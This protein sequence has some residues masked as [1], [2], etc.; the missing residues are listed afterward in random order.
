MSRRDALLLGAALTVAGAGGLPR[1]ARAADPIRIGVLVD[2]SGLYSD[3]SGPTSVTA[4]QMA[5]AEV[6][7]VLGRPVEVIAADHQNQPDLGSSIAREWFD[8]RGVVAIADMTSSAVALAVQKLASDKGKVTLAT[9][10]TTTALINEGCSPT[11][12]LWVQDSYSNTA[13]PSRLLLRQGLSSWFMI[14]ADYAGGHQMQ[15]ALHKAVTDGGGTVVGSTLHPVGT[16]DFSSY[17]LQAQASGAQ[18]VG[19]LNGG[20]DLVNSIKQAA[21]F[22]LTQTQ[23]FFLPG[24]VISDI[25]SLGLEQA[26]GL[27]LMNSFYWDRNDESR[28]WSRAFFARTNRMPGQIQAGTYSAVRHFL[29]SAQLAGSTDGAAV[30]ESMRSTPVDDVFVHDG[31]IRPDGRLVHDFYVVQVK[32]P[33]ESR[34]PWDCYK[35]VGTIAGSE[36]MQPLAQT[37]CPYLVKQE[38]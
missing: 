36:A 13:G 8:E 5:A 18:V 4:A 26:Q 17:L 21:E 16:A 1:P 31:H 35:Q 2:M 32:S 14:V 27:L 24:A 9:G 12:F 30:A 10:P 3:Y 37:R 7:D 28:A 23:K 29:K 11:G 20:S 6:G 25:H 33:A 34:A 19:L 38:Q 22:G 15:A